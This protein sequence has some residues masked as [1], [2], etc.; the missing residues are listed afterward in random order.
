MSRNVFSGQQIKGKLKILCS[1]RSNVNLPLF[2]KNVLPFTVLEV[3]L[4]CLIR[5]IRSV[6]IIF[7]V[8][9]NI[10]NKQYSLRTSLSHNF[11]R[12][13]LFP[14]S[15]HPH[16]A[17]S[18]NTSFSEGFGLKLPVWVSGMGFQMVFFGTSRQ[19]NRH[20]FKLECNLPQ[21]FLPISSNYHVY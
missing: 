4:S 15:L 14:N 18:I 2:L 21:Y 5:V 8:A 3:N 13:T 17:I 20:Y 6:Y 16:P 9:L 19:I 12:L 10:L 1:L 11:F 7:L